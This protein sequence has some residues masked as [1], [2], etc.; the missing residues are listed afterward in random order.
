MKNTVSDAT[1]GQSAP[2]DRLGLAN[3]LFHEFYASC[4]WHLRPDLTIT[5]AKIPLVVKGLRSHGG[6]RG[7]ELAAQL[8]EPKAPSEPCH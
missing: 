1:A 4:F 3:R 6:K 7:L 5:E 8:T 2:K